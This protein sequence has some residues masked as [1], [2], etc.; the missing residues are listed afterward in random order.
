MQVFPGRTGTKAQRSA[1]RE[2]PSSLS[3]NPSCVWNTEKSF[4]DIDVNKSCKQPWCYLS[5]DQCSLAL[6]TSKSCLPDIC[7]LVSATVC[8]STGTLS[9]R[10]EHFFQSFVRAT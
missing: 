9:R 6:I 1:P 2:E 5:G 10:K 4:S 7:N 8:T 3:T